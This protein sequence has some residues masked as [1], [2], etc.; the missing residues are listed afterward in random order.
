[1]ILGA[2]LGTV[3]VWITGVIGIRIE[4]RMLFLWGLNK[5]GLST[6]GSAFSKLSLIDLRGTFPANLFIKGIL[7]NGELLSGAS[8]FFANGLSKFWK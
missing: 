4:S 5:M 7:N 2:G 3:G 6:P 8:F 1:M